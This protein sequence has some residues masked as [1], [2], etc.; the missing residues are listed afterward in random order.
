MRKT[1]IK[2]TRGTLPVVAIP[3]LI[4]SFF[5]GEVPTSGHLPAGA[6]V[7]RRLVLAH[8]DRNPIQILLAYATG[9]PYGQI[10]AL[11]GG[12]LKSHTTTRRGRM[13]KVCNLTIRTITSAAL[14]KALTAGRVDV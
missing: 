5:P 13:G 8:F 3:I 7:K 9:R 2:G 4:D 11:F 14:D 12:K 10:G 1:Q 6:A